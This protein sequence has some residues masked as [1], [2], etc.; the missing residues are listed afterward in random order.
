MCGIAGVAA[1]SGQLDPEVRA[2][3]PAMTGALR[4]RGPDG[5]G[6]FTDDFVG[7]GHRRL[8]IIDREGGK[9]PLANE[10]GSCWITFNGEIYNHRDLRTELVAR[11]HQFRTRS[12]TEAIV[13]AYEEFGASCVDHLEGMF[14]FAVYDQRR[15][16]LF[17]ARDRLGKKPLYYAILS[18]V[19]HF[20]S[21]IK[22]FY[23][24]PAWNG[25]IGFSE[26]ESY[27]SLGYFLAPGTVY[28]HVR[29]L[30][31]GHWLRLRNGAVEVRRYWDVECFDDYQGTEAAAVEILDSSLR[32]RGREQ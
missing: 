19:L 1:V 18:G 7:L 8:A 23:H 14:A 16:E 29:K 27:L 4:H 22:A 25:A 3:L 21:E 13:H 15:R 28:Q 31:P 5:E 9:Q 30:E 11:G 6:F 20:A 32:A 24:S 10:D 26:L 12:A 17:I 2:A